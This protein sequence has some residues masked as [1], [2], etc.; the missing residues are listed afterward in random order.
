MKNKNRFSVL[1]RPS[2]N[3]IYRHAFTH[4]ALSWPDDLDTGTCKIPSR[5]DQSIRNLEPEQDIETYFCPYD[6]DL[7]PMTLTWRV[8][9]YT[10]I[11]K[12]CQNFRKLERY[13]QTYTHRQLRLKALP[14]K[15][16]RYNYVGYSDQII[17][18]IRLLLSI[19]FNGFTYLLKMIEMTYLHCFCFNYAT[20]IPKRGNM[21]TAVSPEIMPIA[22][23]IHFDLWPSPFQS[24]P[25]LSWPETLYTWVYTLDNTVAVRFTTLIS[26]C[27][28]ADIATRA[29]V[30]DD[31][32]L[33]AQ[34]IDRSPSRSQV[35]CFLATLMRQQLLSRLALPGLR[36]APSSS[37]VNSSFDTSRY[38]LTPRTSW[39]T[40]ATTRGFKQM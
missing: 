15:I 28:R 25:H 38:F 4:V 23:F 6:L 8:W 30:H 2:A 11:S 18:V 19:N 35:S 13:R 40:A 5:T 1:G 39:V 37:T 26:R 14:I 31:D 36:A 10:C 32:G 20:H 3:K 12:K 9:K 27:T 34:H 22:E 33:N 24:N 16:V 17:A 7:D 21:R 29:G